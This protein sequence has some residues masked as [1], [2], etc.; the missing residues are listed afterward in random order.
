MGNKQFNRLPIQDIKK[1]LAFIDTVPSGTLQSNK[2]A[3]EIEL[4]S[5]YV[6]L[7]T[8]VSNTYNTQKRVYFT[9]VFF[10][11][12]DCVVNLSLWQKTRPRG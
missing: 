2:L 7:S 6:T 8:K 11:L 10:E 12:T 4:T 5:I 1:V 3:A 9:H